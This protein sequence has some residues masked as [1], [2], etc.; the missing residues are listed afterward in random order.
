MQPRN[1]SWLV[2]LCLAALFALPHA[3]GRYQAST[4]LIVSFDIAVEENRNRPPV[5]QIYYD[6]GKGFRE[7]ES[8][9]AVLPERAIPKAI[10]AH[11][12]ASSIHALRLDYLDG[13]GRVRISGLT[14]L[15]PFG[16]QLAAN[17]SAAQFTTHQTTSL[18]QNGES[19]LMQSSPQA[20]DPHIALAFQPALS[21]PK[22][23]RIWPNVVF[24][25]KI[26]ALLGVGLEIL[27]LLIGKSWINVWIRAKKADGNK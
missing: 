5:L 10:Q 4:R 25:F 12:P 8:M 3:T 19:L 13:P 15:E 7:Q 26:F 14:I 20:D 22:Q 1:Y 21:T 11:L 6:T 18:Q 2:S 9:R 16:A 17:F 24:G 27:F 23:E